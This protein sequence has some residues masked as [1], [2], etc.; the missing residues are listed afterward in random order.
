MRASEE[1]RQK[2][3]HNYAY[4]YKSLGFYPCGDLED[5]DQSKT[6]LQ[7][8]GYVNPNEK[9]IERRCV[10][11]YLCQDMGMTEEIYEEVAGETEHI[12]FEGKT[13]F[14]KFVDRRAVAIV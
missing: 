8:E 14:C 2:H 12:W 10:K 7:S 1:Q 13:A 11:N 3:E 9:A 5:R 4:A 6:E